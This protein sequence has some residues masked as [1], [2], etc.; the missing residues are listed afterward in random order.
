MELYPHEILTFLLLT[1][2]ISVNLFSMCLVFRKIQYAAVNTE[3]C[4]LGVRTWPT[5]R[6]GGK[7]APFQLSLYVLLPKL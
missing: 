5:G 2:P 6:W 1:K 4:R 7:V 3:A